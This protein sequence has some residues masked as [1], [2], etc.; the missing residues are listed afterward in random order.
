M[1]HSQKQPACMRGHAGRLKFV[2]SG[3]PLLAGVELNDEL[4]VHDG[5]YFLL[6]ETSDAAANRG[7]EEMKFWVRLGKCDK[8]I[9]IGRDGFH[10]T[11]HGRNGIALTLQTFSLAPDGTEFVVSKTSGTT[12]MPACQVAAENENLIVAQFRYHFRCEQKP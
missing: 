11:L 6:P 2:L 3:T 12:G 5:G 8:C 7:D 10:A 1:V 4:H 9:N